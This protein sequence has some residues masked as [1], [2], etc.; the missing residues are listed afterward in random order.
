M[1]TGYSIRGI[2]MGIDNI[3]SLLLNYMAYKKA[4][5]NDYKN[6]KTFISNSNIFKGKRK[7]IYAK[8][9]KQKNS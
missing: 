8:I 2:K 3:L 6:L 5:A 4:T 1:L 9:N 7:K